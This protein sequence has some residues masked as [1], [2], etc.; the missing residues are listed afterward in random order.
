MIYLT[1]VMAAF[2]TAFAL[3]NLLFTRAVD[4]PGLYE[5]RSLRQL[6]T[7]GGLL[8]LVTAL[9]SIP[10]YL[11]N[12]FFRAKV[13]YTGL[14]IGFLPLTSLSTLGM[15]LINSAAM[16]LVYY[17][18]KHL[19]PQLFMQVKDT[20]PF[21][22]INS[23]TLGSLLIASRMS[24]TSQ[25]FSFFGYCLGAGVGFTAALLILWSVHSR[26]SLTRI[27]KIFRGF[28]ITFLCLGIL[29]LALFGLLGNQLPA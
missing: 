10:A 16:L 27:P 4:I 19:R 22:G 15:L 12:A 24:T 6:L 7:V 18:V 26:L 13:L 17:L 28:P 14:K 3:E 29:S 20:L 2:L 23:V 8:T 1:E 21:Y 9:S 5:K 25:F 11:F